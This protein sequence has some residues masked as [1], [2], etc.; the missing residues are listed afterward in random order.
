MN[1]I[2]LTGAFI[3]TLAL[4]SYGIGSIS[5]Q[6]FK[7]VSPGVLW[8]LSL[9][10]VLHVVATV[11]MIIGSQNTPFTFH[12]FLG[13]SALLAMLIDVILIWHIYFEKKLY[14]EI[15]ERLHVYSRIAYYYFI[16][17]YITGSLLEIV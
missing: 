16:I 2:S 5:I 13:Y 1:P 6:R 3:V 17:T 7:M 8:F 12:G 15:G 4:L 14:A 10:V 9:G 11:F